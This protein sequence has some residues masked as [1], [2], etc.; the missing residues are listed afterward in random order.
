MID[1]VIFTIRYF[2]PFHFPLRWY[3]VIVM[4]GVIVGLAGNRAGA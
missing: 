4:I 1:P 3:G 2:R